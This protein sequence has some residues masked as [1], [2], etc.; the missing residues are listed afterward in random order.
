MRKQFW[1]GLLALV[2]SSWLQAFELKPFSAS[3]RFNLDNKLSGTATRTLES[4]GPN[5]WRYTFSASAP[6]ASAIETSDFLFDGRT[7]TSL[8]Y[9][10]ESKLLLSKK[11]ARVEFDW[12]KRIVSGIREG[13]RSRQFALQPGTLDTLNME[14]QIRRDLTDLGKLGGPYKLAMPKE[15]SP[16]GLVVDGEETLDTPLGKLRTVRVSRKHSDP[17][18]QTTLWLAKDYGYLPAK[19][20]Q[21]DE[22][23]LYILELT[24]Y[25]PAK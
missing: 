24:S 14:V 13:K 3:Y 21:K 7:V 9:R 1:L 20:T 5:R 8:G 23:A 25:K 2:A 18:R 22:E 6:I 15:L 17:S 16:L 12:K 19:V 4:R 11:A 10:Q